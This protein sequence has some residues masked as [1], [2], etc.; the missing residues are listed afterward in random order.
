MI[1]NS[2][3]EAAHALASA[4]PGQVVLDLTQTHD[5]QAV[6]EETEAVV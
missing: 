5:R 4:T 2:S 3:D 6:R 1:G